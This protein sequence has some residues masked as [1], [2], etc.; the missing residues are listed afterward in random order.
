[1][2]GQDPEGLHVGRGK[3]HAGGNGHSQGL[4]HLAVIA[5]PAFADVVEQGADD[6]QVGAADPPDQG[7]G[8]HR[9][10]QQVPVHGVAVEGVALRPV[11]HHRPFGDELHP[12]PGL[13]EGLDGADGGGTGVEQADQGPAQFFGPWIRRG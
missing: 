2:A 1:M 3:P 7:A 9:C 4:A 5:G 12:Q 6:E 13:V 8:R 10:L 11:A